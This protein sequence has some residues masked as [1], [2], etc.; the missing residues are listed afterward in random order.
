MLLRTWSCFVHLYLHTGNLTALE[1]GLR[2]T[3]GR[4]VTTIDYK[5]HTLSL[6]TLRSSVPSLCNRALAAGTD[7]RLVKEPA[8]QRS[9]KELQAGTA[10]DT[11]EHG[12]SR[13]RGAGVFVL[14]P[15]CRFS[16]H[17]G[18]AASRLLYAEGQG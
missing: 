1:A 6:A 10:S 4:V 15:A 9:R 8:C 2:T 13:G 11:T 17:L 5:A 7:A 12:Q 18:C 14:A 3:D 16:T